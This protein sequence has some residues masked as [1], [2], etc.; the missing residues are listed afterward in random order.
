MRKSLLIIILI[1]SISGCT[2]TSDELDNDNSEFLRVADS[3]YQDIYFKFPLDLEGASDKVSDYRTEIA[4]YELSDY[5]NKI[6]DDLNWV[7]S[8]VE[9]IY[10]YYQYSGEI[11]WEN[12]HIVE[13]KLEQ[14][15]N[16]IDN[17]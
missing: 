2:E 12:S 9:T 13:D 14:I 3:I 11:D 6:R 8:A 10:N 1:I 15:K 4:K 5:C 16:N 7:F 17:Y